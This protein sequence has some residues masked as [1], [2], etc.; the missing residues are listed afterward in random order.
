LRTVVSRE[1]LE[2]V[3]DLFEAVGRHGDLEAALATMTP[4][5]EWDMSG[6]AGW[7]EERSYRGPDA[8][9]EF[10]E[11]WIG[12]WSQWSFDI[13][14]IADAGNQVFVAIR[15]WGLGADSG[16]GVEQRRFFAW[17]LQDG[18]TASVRMFSCRSDALEAVGLRR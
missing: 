2:L 5:V 18:L 1:N 9:R 17:R 13:E 15:E 16:A 12:S 6:V 4:D 14:E 8:V 7:P 3:R 11:G 10:L